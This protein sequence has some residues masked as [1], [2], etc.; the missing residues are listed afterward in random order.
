[1]FVFNF[2]PVPRENYRVGAPLPGLYRELI[3][4]D[5]ACYGGS[6]AGAG[7]RVTSDPEP[8]HGQ[9]CSLNLSLPP[10]GMLVLK[11]E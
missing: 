3:N 4:S 11:P 8:W 1:V 10:L 2:T 5:A 7:G 6:G 9:P